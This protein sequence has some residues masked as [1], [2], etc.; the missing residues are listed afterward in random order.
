MFWPSR[1]CAEMAQESPGAGPRGPRRA[2]ERPESEEEEVEEEEEERTPQ[3]GAVRLP[4]NESRMP[5]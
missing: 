5:H 2:R 1:R 3:G 4:T